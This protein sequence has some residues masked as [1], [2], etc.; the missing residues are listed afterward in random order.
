[1]DFLSEA[2]S[3]ATDGSA[4]FSP[5]EDS[6]GCASA[7][8]DAEA[9]FA[10]SDSSAGRHETNKACHANIRNGNSKKPAAV[11]FKEDPTFILSSTSFRQ[12]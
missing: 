6:A 10:A 8:P 3:S 4:D 11:F 7:P 12:H 2:D 5:T 1:L 9:S